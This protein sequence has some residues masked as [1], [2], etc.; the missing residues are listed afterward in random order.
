MK[1]RNFDPFLVSYTKLNSKRNID[2]NV[3]QNFKNSRRKHLW[4]CIQQWFLRYNHIKEQIGRLDFFKIKN[5][6]SK[7]LLRKW[8]DSCR[9]RENIKS[10]VWWRNCIDEYV[11]N[12]QIQYKNTAL[13]KNGQKIGLHQRRHRDS[14]EA[15]EKML[16]IVSH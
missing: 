14:K 8:K 9:P 3:K 2:L 7:T 15:C 6:S 4:S 11:N 1:N 12:S 16:N 5:C 10:Y 13:F